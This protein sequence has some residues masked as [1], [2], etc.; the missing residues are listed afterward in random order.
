MRFSTLFRS[1]QCFHSSV[2]TG[3][4]M[5][6]I[7][8]WPILSQS[9]ANNPG[10]RLG[11]SLRYQNYEWDEDA[12]TQHFNALFLGIICP[13]SF[14]HFARVLAALCVRHATR[15]QVKTICDVPSGGLWII[16]NLDHLVTIGLWEH[17]HSLYFFPVFL[18]DDSRHRLS[19]SMTVNR[20]V[21][22]VILQFEGMGLWYADIMAF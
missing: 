18:P 16:Y 19:V 6:V 7:S 8:R 17:G 14:K 10:A 2:T 4:S 21:R 9:L 15:S 11:A 3:S 12:H 22:G 13:S 1:A 20:D 5:V